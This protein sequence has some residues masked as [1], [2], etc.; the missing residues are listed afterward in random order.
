[1]FSAFFGHY[2][3]NKGIVTSSELS[4]VLEKQ[5]NVRLK[6]GV[7]AINAGMMNATQ[8]EEVHQLQA[9]MD[10]RFGEIAIDNNYIT[11]QQ[12]V[13]LLGQQKEEYLLLA[14]SLIDTGHM[15]M[16]SFE[17]EVNLYKIERGL[18]DDQ[19]EAIKKGNVDVIVTAFVAFESSQISEFYIDFV[20]IFV[21]NIIRFVD[22]N[23]YIDRVERIDCIDYKHLFKQGIKTTADNEIFTGYSGDEEAL[24]TVA[25]K[26]AEEEFNDL[27]E[28]PLD[29]AKE[30]LNLTN[31][32]FI[33][34]MSNKGTEMD[35]T[36]QEYE[37]SASLRVTGKMY[38]IPIHISS[39]TI[40]L[41]IGQL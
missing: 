40:N 28:Y 37:H 36:I 23:I 19:F 16:A 1:M 25:G 15:T 32:L 7:L 11:D 20:K 31:G 27:S 10:R 6:L 24:I 18:S 5:K 21:K 12:L 41:L 33:V 29:S 30:F 17:E 14:Q 22:T 34:N 4:D 38:R 8:V 9:S 39:G 35:L 2:L 3:L 13:E 26:H